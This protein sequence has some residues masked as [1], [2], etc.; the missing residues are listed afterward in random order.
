MGQ[1]IITLPDGRRAQVTFE[2]Q[3]QL[4][5]VISSLMAQ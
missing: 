1:A 4:D 2:S 5:A 3:E